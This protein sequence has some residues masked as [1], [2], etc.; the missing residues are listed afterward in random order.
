MLVVAP[1]PMAPPAPGQQPQRHTLTL[2]GAALAGGS[3]AH[4]RAGKCAPAPCWP[5]HPA[6][7]GPTPSAATGPLGRSSEPC[8]TYMHTCWSHVTMTTTPSDARHGKAMPEGA[9]DGQGGEGEAVGQAGAVDV[10][11]KALAAP[12][13]LV[14]RLQEKSAGTHARTQ[15][16]PG[17]ACGA[18]Q[19]VGV[20]AGKSTCINKHV[21]GQRRLATPR[22]RG[23]AA[24]RL[25]SCMC[26]GGEP[27]ACS[28]PAGA[29]AAAAA[30][31]ACCSCSASATPLSRQCAAPVGADGR[32]AALAAVAD[33]AL[34]EADGSRGARL[35]R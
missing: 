18:L 31:V 22:K 6:A 11:L 25:T 23:A 9:H 16:A 7:R 15:R 3:H 27:G 5:P 13:L 10:P 21:N 1:R 20:V 24:H 12:G 34:V 2:A 19:V 29:P 35:R 17:R 28:A 4:S 26:A 33:S 30:A 8:A 14:G 32:Q